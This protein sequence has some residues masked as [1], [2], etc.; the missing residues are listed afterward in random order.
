MTVTDGLADPS[1]AVIT[2]G[3][4]DWTLPFLVL[5]LFIYYV[6]K[7]IIYPVD[8]VPIPVNIQADVPFSVILEFLN[9][10]QL[11]CPLP[12]LTQAVVLVSYRVSVPIYRSADLAGWGILIAFADAI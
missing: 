6:P 10:S 3:D 5:R 12:H 8:P 7:D 9:V 2:E 4:D 11:V 1:Q